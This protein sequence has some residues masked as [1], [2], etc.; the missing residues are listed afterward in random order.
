MNPLSQ[1]LMQQYISRIDLSDPFKLA[2]FAAVLTSADGEEL[3]RVLEAADP[4]E[5][6]NIA[7][8]L[9]MKEKEVAKLQREIARQVDEKMSKQQREYLLKEQLKSIKQVNLAYKSAIYCGFILFYL[10][11]YRN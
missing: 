11:S 7:L 6:L 5:R 3:Q 8:E 2:D 9:L 1:E 4:I 10:S